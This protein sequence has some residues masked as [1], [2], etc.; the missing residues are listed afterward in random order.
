MVHNIFNQPPTALWVYVFA[1]IVLLVLSWIGASTASSLDPRGSGRMYGGLLFLVI[2]ILLGVLVYFLVAAD[3]QEWAWFIALLPT[4]IVLFGIYFAFFG[5][6]GPVGFWIGVVVAFFVMVWTIY[7]AVAT[8]TWSI[9]MF[10]I[11]FFLIAIAGGLSYGM[12]T[13]W[14]KE[15]PLATEQLFK[16][17]K[18]EHEMG[19]Q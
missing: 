17:L 7:E 19:A 4:A 2:S 13:K 15:N 12:F 5:V 18:D 1:V 11:V 16:V 9:L 3:V 6:F 8:Q 10:P 14:N